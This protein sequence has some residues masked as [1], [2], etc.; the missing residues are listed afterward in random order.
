MHASYGIDINNEETP[1][2]VPFHEIFLRDLIQWFRCWI[3]TFF[4][5]KASYDNIFEIFGKTVH[6]S[7]MVLLIQLRYKQFLQILYFSIAS[8]NLLPHSLMFLHYIF[9]QNLVR[10]TN[11]GS[12]PGYVNLLHAVWDN[13]ARYAKSIDL[14]WVT[15]GSLR[16]GN[17]SSA[18]LC[19]SFNDDHC[20]GGDQGHNVAP[21]RCPGQHSSP[22]RSAPGGSRSITSSN[23]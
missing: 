10:S 16:R 1:L 6:I 3:P 15:P 8:W 7:H 12:I 9:L 21:R 4:R 14:G 20:G 2:K 13:L 17:L 18:R 5:F 23:I 22:T 11:I 19:G